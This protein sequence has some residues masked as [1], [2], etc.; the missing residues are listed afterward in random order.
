M[1]PLLLASSSAYR[2]ELLTRLRLPFPWASPDLAE[3]RLDGGAQG[4]GQLQHLV[5]GHAVQ[6]K[7]RKLP[8]PD[9][10]PQD[11]FQGLGPCFVKSLCQPQQGL[12]GAV[13]EVAPRA[14]NMVLLRICRHG[15]AMGEV[16][17][18]EGR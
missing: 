13:V 1:L 4:L 12:E 5:A 16:Q 14:V 8:F 15:L 10:N 6:R 9:Q 11:G 18:V 3:R 2:R 17:R 7:L